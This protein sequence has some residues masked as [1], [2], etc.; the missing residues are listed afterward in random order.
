MS[1]QIQIYNIMA[2]FNT[3]TKETPK[4]STETS[5]QNTILADFQVAIEENALDIYA[6]TIT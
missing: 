4:I 1:T 5:P 2:L 6:Y 3:K